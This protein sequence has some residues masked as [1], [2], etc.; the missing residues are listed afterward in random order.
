[1]EAAAAAALRSPT[2]AAAPPRRSA[3]P[4]ASSLLFDRR[5]SFAFGSIE[6]GTSFWFLSTVYAGIKEEISLDLMLNFPV[7]C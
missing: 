4:G 1:M 7:C 5:R 3:A 2:A 6:V